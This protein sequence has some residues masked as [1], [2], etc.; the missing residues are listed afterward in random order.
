MVAGQGIEPGELAAPTVRLG[1]RPACSASGV[2]GSISLCPGPSCCQVQAVPFG[3]PPL[4]DLHSVQMFSKIVLNEGISPMLVTPQW[5]LQNFTKAGLNIG[6]LVG[7][8][9]LEAAFAYLASALFL[10][11]VSVW[12]G[13]IWGGVIDL[14]VP[15][16][17]L[18]SSLPAP[19]API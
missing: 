10:L 19:S 3:S 11:R 8:E 14:G 9:N 18:V 5:L 15:S 16:Q 1:G 13:L 6:L 7:R 12:F 17:T 4:W 2:M